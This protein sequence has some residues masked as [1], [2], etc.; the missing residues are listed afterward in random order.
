LKGLS[1]FLRECVL[2][3][4][5]SLVSLRPGVESLTR[6]AGLLHRWLQSAPTYREKSS[7]F[8]GLSGHISHT[9][10]AIFIHQFYGAL[11]RGWPSYH[12]EQTISLDEPDFIVGRLQEDAVIFLSHNK[13]ISGA[14][15]ERIAQF[16]WN[17]DA[18]G[19]IDFDGG[20]HNGI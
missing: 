15:A 20:S 8:V 17:D 19:L 16:F 10:F 18:T 12:H 3:M 2:H 5:L 7:W 6:N 9:P 11:G 1:R 14:D 4:P 13:T